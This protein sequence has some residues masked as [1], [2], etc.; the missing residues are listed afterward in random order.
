MR[1][2]APWLLLLVAGCGSLTETEDGVA[3]LDVVRPV[4]TTLAPG[5]TLQ[6]T[7]V[8]LDARGEPVDAEILWS[9][10]DAFLAV[11]EATGLVTALEPGVGGRI[12]A[13]TGTGSRTLYSDLLLLTVAAPPAPIP[14]PR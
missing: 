11:E 8:A 10:A 9:S 6:L 2:L 5:A 3:F 7:A 4:T 1:H 13:R 14:S 12:Q